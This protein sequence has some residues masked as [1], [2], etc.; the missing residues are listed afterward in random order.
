MGLKDQVMELLLAADEPG[1]EALVRTEPRVSRHLLG[2]LWDPDEDMRG[3]AARALGAF[4]VA[5][6]EQTTD[7]L[8]RLL[9]GIN[10]ESATNGV[11]GIAAIGEIGYRRPD[12]AEAFV[13]PLASYLWDDGLR[14]SIL[15]ALVRI[16]ESAPEF[17]A[18][19][20]E[21]I[22]GCRTKTDSEHRRLVAQL[23]GDDRGELH[24]N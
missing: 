22:E 9:W 18:P 21:M 7:I 8:R 2:R 16:Q 3:R 12:L 1:L 20:G 17:I 4:A 11:Y 14:L 23:L 15:R 13:A 24:E 6:P 10:D 19:L 5:H